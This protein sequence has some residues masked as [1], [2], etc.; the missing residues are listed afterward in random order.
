MTKGQMKIKEAKANLT[1]N[2]ETKQLQANMIDW[3]TDWA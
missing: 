1:N 2:E 3:E